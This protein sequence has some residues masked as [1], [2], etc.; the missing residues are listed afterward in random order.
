[1]PPDLMTRC[2]RRRQCVVGDITEWRW[3]DVPVSEAIA[4]SSMSI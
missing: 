4:S 1:M 3:K 2:E